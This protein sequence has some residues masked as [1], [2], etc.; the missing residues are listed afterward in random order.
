MS[1]VLLLLFNRPDLTEKLVRI[2]QGYDPENLY[3]AVDGP[4]TDHPGEEDLCRA[5]VECVRSVGWSGR[6][7]WLIREKNLGCGV[8]CRS[9]LDWFFEHEES[10]LI[11]E[12]DC[13]PAP[14]FFDFVPSMLEWLRDRTDIFMVS[15]N[16]FLPPVLR[17]G[18][19][20]FRTKYAFIWGWGT[21]RDRWRKYRFQIDSAE[22]PEWVKVVSAACP[23]GFEA[24][25]WTKILY[26]LSAKPVPTSWG[27]QMLLS[28]WSSGLDS[29][30]PPCNL[31]SNQGFRADATHTSGSGDVHSYPCEALPQGWRNELA[32]RSTERDSALFWHHYL[33]AD[34]VVLRNLVLESEP[35]FERR[36]RQAEEL[37]RLVESPRLGDVARIFRTWLARS[38]KTNRP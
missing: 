30:C 38:L 3:V 24:V 6:V 9:A 4:R 36:S 23:A 11:L 14:D 35:L 10:G 34:D 27:Y 37:R 18:S 22:I 28:A 31:V 29:I 20:A 8:A 16:N 12:D 1:A 5:V 19:V 7:H 21:W 25:Y 13:H 26:S 2:V 15:G 33:H 17:S 32:P